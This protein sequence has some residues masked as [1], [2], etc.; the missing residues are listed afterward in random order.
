MNE[1]P[2]EPYMVTEK[3]HGNI[4][5]KQFIESS[6]CKLARFDVEHLPVV[7]TSRHVHELTRLV[8]FHQHI[9]LGRPRP[10][11]HDPP[12]TK[13]L[14]VHPLHLAS[15][16]C[17]PRSYNLFVLCCIAPHACTLNSWP[18]PA[19]IFFFYTS[20]PSTL[21]VLVIIKIATNHTFQ[22]L[23]IQHNQATH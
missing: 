11:G 6:T 21:Y 10:A 8:A 22:Y 20:A 14:Y 18:D 1:G 23:V 16:R 5:C 7:S 2:V 13:A 12:D 9:S 4:V 3:L 17:W 15:D 19:C